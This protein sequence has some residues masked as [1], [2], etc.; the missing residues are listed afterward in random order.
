MMLSERMN[1]KAQSL[2]G[3]WQSA[4][5]LAIWLSYRFDEDLNV[6]TMWL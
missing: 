1:E 4:T 5:E 6:W 3:F 2:S